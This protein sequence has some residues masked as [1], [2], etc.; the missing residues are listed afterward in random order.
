MKTSSTHQVTGTAISQ[1]QTI[2]IPIEA[3]LLSLR[4]LSPQRLRFEL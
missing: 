3:G 2:S 1:R 4:G